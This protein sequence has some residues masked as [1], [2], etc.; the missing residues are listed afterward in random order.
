MAREFKPIFSRVTGLITAFVGM[1]L[2]GS[3]GVFLVLRDNQLPFLSLGGYDYVTLGQIGGFYLDLFGAR[4]LSL[5][6]AAWVITMSDVRH[7]VRTAFWMSLCLELVLI[8]IRMARWPWYAAV[9]LDQS[10]PALAEFLSLVLIVGCTMLFT[11]V[12]S[13]LAGRRS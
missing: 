12:V 9:G 3:A 7:P 13:K 5:W 2:L 8:G 6:F 1:W 10:I 11:W 4:L